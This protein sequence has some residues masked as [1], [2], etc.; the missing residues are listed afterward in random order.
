MEK[1]QSSK[2]QQVVWCFLLC[3]TDQSETNGNTRGKWNDIF[4]SNWANHKEWFLYPMKNK[5]KLEYK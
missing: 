3:L 1:C 2:Y 5:N 4:R